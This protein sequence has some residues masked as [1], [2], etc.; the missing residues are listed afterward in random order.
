M[1][2]RRLGPAALEHAQQDQ[3]LADET[4]QARQADARQRQHEREEGQHGQPPGQAAEVGDLPGVVALVEHA[5]HGEQPAGRQAVVDHLQH[6]A[7]RRSA[8]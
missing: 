7:L 3:K 5:D 1:G 8:G 4:V 2:G 6:A